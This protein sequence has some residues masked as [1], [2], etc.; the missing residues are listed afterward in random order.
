MI[1][2]QRIVKTIQNQQLQIP[3]TARGIPRPTIAWKRKRN[4]QHLSGRVTSR[5]TGDGEYVTNTIT[6]SR[7]QTRDAGVYICTA[8]NKVT[9]RPIEQEVTL[10]VQGIVTKYHGDIDIILFYVT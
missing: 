6:I 5:N 4:G 1:T 7:I 2:R 9:T 8:T 10:V 3:C